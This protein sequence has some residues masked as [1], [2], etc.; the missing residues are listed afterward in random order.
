MILAAYGCKHGEPVGPFHFLEGQMSQNS[1]L[2]LL[3]ALPA[4][5][6]RA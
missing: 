1:I 5:D 6:S 4:V 2:P 3:G